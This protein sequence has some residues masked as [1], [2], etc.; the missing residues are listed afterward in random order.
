M[1]TFDPISQEREVG[2]F[3]D[4]RMKANRRICSGG[5]LFLASFAWKSPQSCLDADIDLFRFL[6]G[7]FFCKI[8]FSGKEKCPF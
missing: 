5:V 8:F 7:Q 4:I 1:N 6:L 2:F 3:G